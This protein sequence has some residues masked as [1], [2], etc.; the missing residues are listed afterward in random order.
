MKLC[1]FNST[2]CGLFPLRRLLITE[3]AS[4][5]PRPAEVQMF[6]R[7]YN[8]AHTQ[9]RPREMPPKINRNTTWLMWISSNQG[10]SLTAPNFICF[11]SHIYVTWCVQ[12]Q[13]CNNETWRTG[14]CE[15]T[16]RLYQKRIRQSRVKTS[17]GQ[18]HICVIAGHKVILR[19]ENEVVSKKLCQ[20]E[21]KSQ[22]IRDSV[23]ESQQTTMLHERGG[24]WWQAR[25]RWSCTRGSALTGESGDQRRL[26]GGERADSRGTQRL[27]TL[28][29]CHCRRNIQLPS[30]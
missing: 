18:P 26:W 20:S 5:D 10:W 11:P 22:N 25:Q 27:P 9:F 3:R 21:I 19:F 2:A 23:T 1:A 24:T 29:V 14:H 17:A 13:V 8:T 6:S 15:R 30:G 4:L 7:L 28:P 16:R 12:M